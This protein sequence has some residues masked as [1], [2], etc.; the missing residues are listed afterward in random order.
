MN[1]G[2][3]RHEMYRRTAILI[4]KI[5]MG[6]RDAHERSVSTEA[7]ERERRQQHEG[8]VPRFPAEPPADQ[9][10]A[11]HQALAAT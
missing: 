3:N 6:A 4:D 5:L 11:S 10:R 9:E 1:F 7:C 8:Q 2:P